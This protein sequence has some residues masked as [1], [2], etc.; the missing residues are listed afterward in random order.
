MTGSGKNSRTEDHPE[1]IGFLERDWNLDQ[2]DHLE[3][4]ILRY[5]PRL[6]ILDPIQSYFP[7]A[8]AYSGPT[9]RRICSMPAETT[10]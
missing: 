6:A 7:G 9:A 4:K 3:A 8:G 1:R 5:K 10:A 2:L